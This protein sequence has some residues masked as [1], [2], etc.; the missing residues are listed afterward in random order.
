MLSDDFIRLEHRLLRGLASHQVNSSDQE[1]RYLQFSL[2][3][4]VV[5]RRSR[6][7]AMG[8]LSSSTLLVCINQAL[9][10]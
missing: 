9:S 2:N 7:L 5:L 3:L 8:T 4:Q 1:T 10:L 6:K